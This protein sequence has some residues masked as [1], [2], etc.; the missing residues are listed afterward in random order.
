MTEVRYREGVPSDAN[1]IIDFQIAMA[2]ETED[3]YLERDVTTKGVHAV[4]AD[5]SH[6]RYFVAEAGGRVVASLMTRRAPEE[7][8]SRTR[9]S[10]LDDPLLKTMRPLRKTLCRVSLRC[11]DMRP[12]PKC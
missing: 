4:F 10:K 1:D 5:P 8:M 12:A 3:F 7:D 9:Q 11:S 2:R 6:G